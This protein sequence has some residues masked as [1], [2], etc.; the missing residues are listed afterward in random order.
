MKSKDPG[1]LGPMSEADQRALSERRAWLKD[2]AVA[3]QKPL[4]DPVPVAP[5]PGQLEMFPGEFTL[6]SQPKRKGRRR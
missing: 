4:P 6:T 3:A 5:L 1:P 2:Q